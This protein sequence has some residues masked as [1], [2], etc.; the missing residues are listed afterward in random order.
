[1]AYFGLF[2]PLLRADVSRTATGPL[3][4]YIIGRPLSVPL[5]VVIVRTIHYLC[6]E[7]LFA[8]V[9]AVST[10]IVVPDTAV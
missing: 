6:P 2:S 7:T 9:P 4:R 8:F 1:M 5:S 10:G 3:T